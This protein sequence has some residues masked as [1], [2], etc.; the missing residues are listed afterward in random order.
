M[1]LYLAVNTKTN[2]VK[3]FIGYED[4]RE[5]SIEE[6]YA[7]DYFKLS[8]LEEIPDVDLFYYS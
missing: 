6:R 7:Y 4:L 1:E 2:D 3:M 5:F 8:N